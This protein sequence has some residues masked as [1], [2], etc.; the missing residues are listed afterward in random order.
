[1]RP[2]HGAL[3]AFAPFSVLPAQT[4]P[5]PAAQGPEWVVDLLGGEEV[6][7]PLV[8]VRQGGS[9]PELVFSQTDGEP[10][11]VPLAGMVSGRIEGTSGLL[12]SVAAARAPVEIRTAGGEVF[13]GS[14]RGGDAAGERID[15]ASTSLGD[16]S[17]PID[18]VALVLFVEQLRQNDP[19]RFS[20][21][22]PAAQDETLFQRTR[23][24]IDPI[25]GI[26]NRFTP[27]GVLFHWK[28]AEKPDLFA[29]DKLVAIAF[30][31]A[32]SPK[33]KPLARWLLRDGSLIDATPSGLKEGKLSLRARKDQEFSID[34]GEVSAFEVRATKHL[35]VSE[36]APK[37]VKETPYLGGSDDFLFPH[38]RDRAVSG[39]YLTVAGRS[40]LRG[41]GCHSRT[42]LTYA[43]PEGFTVLR[44][45]IG[46][47]DEARRLAVPGNA[48]FRVL[49]DGKQVTEIANV[50]GGE[51]PRRLE[52]VSLLGAKEFT[53]EVDFGGDFHLGDR[54]D[55][56][57]TVL[58]RG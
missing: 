36:L 13:C 34:S 20:A 2:I 31:N 35:F 50:K 16:Q 6:R 21:S 55:W 18:R 29:Y 51:P 28:G 22:R 26:V 52:D 8:G 23:A 47:D 10:R 1:M 38:R 41:I 17:L 49:V 24:G 7:G 25:D 54:A 45:R 14:I 42:A 39:G 33:D 19:Q 11:L 48:V 4:A 46:I 57:G 5:A 37:Q 3:F 15:L 53:L 40:F 12:T 9:G 32:Q 56:L 58:I 44:T 30:R 27:E 43:V